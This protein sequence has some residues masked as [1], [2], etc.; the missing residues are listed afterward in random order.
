MI[1]RGRGR[2][3][4]AGS[5]TSEM[6]SCRAADTQEGRTGVATWGAGVVRSSLG[7]PAPVA[8]RNPCRPNQSLNQSNHQSVDRSINRST[9]QSIALWLL[10]RL[11]HG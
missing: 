4:G 11:L 5:G 7:G 3:W 8:P 10:K 6:G 1:H 9:N 2:G